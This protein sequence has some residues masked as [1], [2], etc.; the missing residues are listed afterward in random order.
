M[1]KAASS[2]T[3]N[4]ANLYPSVGSQHLP[5][6]KTDQVSCLYLMTKEEIVFGIQLCPRIHG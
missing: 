4:E 3:L 2:E 1:E 5:L 6:N